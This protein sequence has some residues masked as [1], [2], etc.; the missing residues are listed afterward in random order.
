MTENKRFTRSNTFGWE[1]GAFLEVMNGLDEKN[2]KL[3]EEIKELKKQDEEIKSLKLQNKVLL[4]EMKEFRD[5]LT[6]YLQII[7]GDFNE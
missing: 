6:I 4:E 5:K 2:R 1:K 7:G 3:K